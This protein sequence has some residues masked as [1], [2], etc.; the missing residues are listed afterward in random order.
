MD[1]FIVL[2]TWRL[3]AFRLMSC[4]ARFSDDLC[5][6]IAKLLVCPDLLCGVGFGQIQNQ[7]RP[8]VGGIWYATPSGKAG[9]DPSDNCP[10]VVLNHELQGLP[11]AG[12]R[13]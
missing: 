3:R 2:K 6:A 7:S 13:C 9:T 12:S 10:L 4:L 8:L 11:M 5:V 1:V